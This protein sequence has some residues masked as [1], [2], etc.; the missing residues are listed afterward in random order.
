[1]VSLREVQN[2]VP[3]CV[4]RVDIPLKTLR[5]NLDLYTVN[6][7]PYYQRGYVWNLEQ[8]EKFVGA[9]LASNRQIPPIWLNWTNKRASCEVVDGKQRMNACL[10]WLNGEIVA[11]CPCGEK[12]WYKDVEK[13]IT[14]LTINWLFVELDEIEV[15]RFY[16]RLNAGGTVHSNLDLMRVELFIQEKLQMRNC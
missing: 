16:L 8:S 15:M 13:D 9:L 4:Y 3:P 11:K 5:Q 2:S 1:M 6:L 12:F 14:F 7:D 10:K